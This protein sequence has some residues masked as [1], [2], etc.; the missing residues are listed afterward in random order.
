M[1][2]NIWPALRQS[3]PNVRLLD[4]VDIVVVAVL[5]YRVLIMI[6]GTRALQILFGLGLV[7]IVY[8]VSQMLG[9]YTLNWLLSTFL[10]SLI[11]VVVLLFQPEIR[12]GL[13]RFARNPFVTP[14]ATG[15]DYIEVSFDK[16]LELA[17]EIGRASCRER[18]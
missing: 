16:Q 18:V 3:L 1:D 4:L 17:S 15:G 10:G 14:T 8:I 12:R 2:W 7:F 13:A 6:R 5:I 9:L 11:L